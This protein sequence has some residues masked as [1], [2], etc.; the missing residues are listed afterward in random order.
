MTTAEIPNELS[1]PAT[2][3]ERIAWLA[4]TLTP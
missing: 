2:T 3:E 4:L 1:I